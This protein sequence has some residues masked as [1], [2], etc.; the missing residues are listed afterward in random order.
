MTIYTVFALVDPDADEFLVAGVIEGDHNCVDSESDSGDFQR[1]ATTVEA[2]SPD[3]AEA[4]AYEQYC[5]DNE[6]NEDDDE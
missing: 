2:D 1:Y 5:E 4:A 6:D 3:G